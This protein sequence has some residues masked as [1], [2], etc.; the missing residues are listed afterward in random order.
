MLRP[1]INL[2]ALAFATFLP[3][4]LFANVAADVSI[5]TD[6]VVG[7]I[8]ELV[9]K[10]KDSFLADPVSVSI[11]EGRVQTLT[12][13]FGA[14]KGEQEYVIAGSI[15]GIFPGTNLGSI[16]VPL[17]Y[18][19]YTDLLLMRLDSEIFLDFKG[20]LDAKGKAT[21]KINLPEGLS[22]KV[23]GAVFFHSAIIFDAKTGKP[24]LA[25]EIA[26]MVL[27]P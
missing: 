6:D 21:A 10:D 19:S 13:D 18:D 4:T 17:N 15:S 16:S 20:R 22:P 8:I 12:L 9:G 7:D 26:E 24:E 23:V 14:D 3:L 27:M 1:S 25:S 2:A 5:D 11:T